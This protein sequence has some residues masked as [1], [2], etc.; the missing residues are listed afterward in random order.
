MPETIEVPIKDWLALHRRIGEAEGLLSGWM[1]LG[2][3]ETEQVRATERFLKG[4][5]EGVV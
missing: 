4:R 5:V 2:A 3:D 1:L